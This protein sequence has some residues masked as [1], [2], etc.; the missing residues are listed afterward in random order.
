MKEKIYRGLVPLTI[1]GLLLFALAES[2]VDAGS[3]VQSLTTDA[4]GKI[5]AHQRDGTSDQIASTSGGH[6]TIEDRITVYKPPGAAVLEI[7]ELSKQVS[8]TGTFSIAST[9]DGN[10]TPGTELVFSTRD[11]GGNLDTALTIEN[12]Q[13]LHVNE[14]LGVGVSP[15]SP[16]HVSGDKDGGFHSQL[17]NTD[18]SG[19]DVNGLLV[20]SSDSSTEVALRVSNSAGAALFDIKGDGDVIMGSPAASVRGLNIETI[21]T[22]QP[23]ITLYQQ[24]SSN[25]LFDALQRAGDDK[26]QVRVYSGGSVVAEIDEESEI[27][28]RTDGNCGV[29]N[30]CSGAFTPTL[31][32]FGGS[33]ACTT[34]TPSEGYFMRVGR[35]ITFHGEFDTTGCGTDWNFEMTLPEGDG[36]ALNEVFGNDYELSGTGGRINDNLV[37]PNVLICEAQ[38]TE[39]KAVCFG[40]STTDSQP[41]KYQLTYQ[42]P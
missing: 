24:G 34:M 6:F 23:G 38:A 32:S 25:R 14:E 16:L 20:Q 10:V 31:D 18:T 26:G 2:M 29:G 36:T 11:S 27:P 28:V 30:V 22:G 21:G 1:L 17:I 39:A 33:T 3:S 19:T 41:V 7:G 35:F 12:D 4:S 8:A 42:L 13:D 37:N 15:T 5:T 40:N 9:G